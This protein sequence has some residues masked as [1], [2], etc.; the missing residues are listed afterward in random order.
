MPR[1]QLLPEAEWGRHTRRFC[2]VGQ[3]WGVHEPRVLF[4]VPSPGTSAYIEALH[5]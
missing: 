5:K 4:P 2:A 3:L 1:I